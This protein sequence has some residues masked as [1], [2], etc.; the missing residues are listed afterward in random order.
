MLAAGFEMVRGFLTLVDWSNNSSQLSKAKIALLFCFDGVSRGPLLTDP[1]KDT[2][3]QVPSDLRLI[4]PKQVT[5]SW[6]G[7]RT[8]K[9]QGTEL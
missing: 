7:M 8:L 4:R 9:P 2:F 1:H 5:S 6:T 3:S